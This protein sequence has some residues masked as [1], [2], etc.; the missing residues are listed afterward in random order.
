MLYPLGA[1]KLFF[2]TVIVPIK[3]LK[4]KKYTKYTVRD[5]TFMPVYIE[6]KREIWLGVTDP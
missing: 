6:K 3:G 2:R 5:S 4:T 1:W